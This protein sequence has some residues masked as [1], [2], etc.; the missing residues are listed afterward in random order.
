MCLDGDMY[1]VCCQMSSYIFLEGVEV[2]ES[3]QDI[4]FRD[5]AR[6]SIEE[7]SVDRESFLISAGRK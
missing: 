2:V 1:D 7:S 5:V 3:W 6:D 4:A